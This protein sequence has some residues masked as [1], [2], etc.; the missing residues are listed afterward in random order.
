MQ[1]NAFAGLRAEIETLSPV[2]HVGRVIGVSGGTLQ[3]SGL[4]SAARM[5]DQLRIVRGDGS[6][7]GGEVI[8]IDPDAITILPDAETD[9]VSRGDRATLMGPARIA[10]HDGWIGRVID[11]YGVPLDGRP[12][13]RGS[14]ER[15]IRCD[16]PPPASRNRLGAR[17]DTG[18]A[19]FNTMLPIVEGQRIGLFA[20]SGVGKSSLLAHFAGHMQADVAVIAL[21]GERGRELRDFVADALGERGAEGPDPCLLPKA[22]KN[23]AE[24]EGSAAA[25]ERDAAAVIECLAWLD[26]QAPGTV[27]EVDV[28]KKLEACRRQANALRVCQSIMATRYKNPLRIGR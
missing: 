3:V 26:A 23:A 2:R 14:H 16:P 15:P 17:L 21:V 7:L 5:G 18:M 12:L 11:P 8:R 1:Q 10:P 13:L 27:T 6:A 20:G 9:G 4:G 19:V 28:V 22:C 24:I 25:H